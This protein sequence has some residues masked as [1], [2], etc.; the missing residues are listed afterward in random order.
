VITG[1]T[2]VVDAYYAQVERSSFINKVLANLKKW[3]EMYKKQKK[4]SLSFRAQG[5]TAAQPSV[6]NPA[7]GI[8]KTP[9]VSL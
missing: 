2:A 7:T 3:S 5:I 9:V 6:F 4:I 1:W 8:W